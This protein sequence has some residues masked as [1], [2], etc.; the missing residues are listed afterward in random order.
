LGRA[1]E[2]SDHLLAFG[3]EVDDFH[4]D[5]GEALAKRGDPT[6]CCGRHL[7]CVDLVDDVQAAGVDDFVDEPPDNGLGVIRS[8][9]RAVMVSL[10]RH[11]ESPYRSGVGDRRAERRRPGRP[12]A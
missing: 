1:A 3:D 2:A 11:C 10:K 5:V 7:R 4:M 8:C 12:A 6:P 9:G